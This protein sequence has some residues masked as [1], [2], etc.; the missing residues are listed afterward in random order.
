MSFLLRE[1]SKLNSD[2]NWLLVRKTNCIFFLQYANKNPIEEVIHL[3]ARCGA[4]DWLVL[5]DGP[6]PP[7]PLPPT[8]YA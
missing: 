5:K 7:S 8:Q 2:T 4:H 6:G 3:G 1:T